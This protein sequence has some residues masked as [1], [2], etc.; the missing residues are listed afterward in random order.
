MNFIFYR[1]DKNSSGFIEEMELREFFANSLLPEIITGQMKPAQKSQEFIKKCGYLDKISLERFTD[2]YINKSVKVN[3][4]AKFHSDCLGEWLLKDEDA[5]TYL[6]HQLAPSGKSPLR[7]KGLSFMVA[8]NDD[9]NEFSPTGY[10]V[11][12]EKVESIVK[13]RDG[14]SKAADINRRGSF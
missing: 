2:Y 13:R 8:R 5:I 1:L 10:N 11:A 7:K 4:D 9:E 12:A 6:A 14:I 3:S